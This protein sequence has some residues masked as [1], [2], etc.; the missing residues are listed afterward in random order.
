MNHIVVKEVLEELLKK[1]IKE[2]CVCPGGRN[3]PF[4]YA[5][6]KAKTLKVYYWP[7]ERSCAFFALGRSR[8]T[9]RPVAIVTTGGYGS[10]LYRCSSS[11][12]DS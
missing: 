1:G 2:F 12:T 6:D 8:L 9:N 7:E 5:L 4:V 11:S 10:P 3:T